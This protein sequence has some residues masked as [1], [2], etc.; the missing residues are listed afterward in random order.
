MTYSQIEQYEIECINN[1]NNNNNNKLKIGVRVCVTGHIYYYT[2]QKEEYVNNKCGYINQILPSINNINMYNILFDDQTLGV[3]I[4]EKLITSKYSEYSEHSSDLKIGDIIKT[5]DYAKYD[6][7]YSAPPNSIGTIKSI[8]ER[9]SGTKHAYYLY[10][11]YIPGYRDCYY[12]KDYITKL[13]SPIIN[14]KNGNIYYSKNPMYSKY[15]F[16]LRSCFPDE[17]GFYYVTIYKNNDIIP[18]NLIGKEL[19]LTLLELNKYDI[20][21]GPNG[22]WSAPDGI[23]DSTNPKYSTYKFMIKSFQPD[24]YGYYYLIIYKKNDLN[25]YIL[26][27]TINI[28]HNNYILNNHPKK[29]KCSICNEKI[30]HLCSKCLFSNNY[31]N[32][33]VLNPSECGITI[34]KCGHVYHEHCIQINQLLYNN[35][36]CL[37]CDEIF[38]QYVFIKPT[39]DSKINRL[40]NRN[41]L[42]YIKYVKN[43]EINKIDNIAKSSNKIIKTKW[44]MSL[45]KK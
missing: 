30:I 28:K 35:K 3:E 29:H 25:Y 37:E 5:L 17:Y 27:P 33:I 34:G 26:N 15:S 19:K 21:Y 23:Y 45:N 11:I 39:I 20:Y 2:L 18:D 41:Y 42:N 16:G 9:Y 8:K 13:S 31:S 36:Y 38:K 14:N 43:N 6:K 44:Y 4:N 1:N 24:T 7:Q 12:E 22:G 10:S 32:D 40:S